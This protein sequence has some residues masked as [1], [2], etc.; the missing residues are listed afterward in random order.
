[1]CKRRVRAEELLMTFSCD[2]EGNEMIGMMCQECLEK[3][4]A[5]DEL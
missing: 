2:A 5:H 4:E 3:M 1:M